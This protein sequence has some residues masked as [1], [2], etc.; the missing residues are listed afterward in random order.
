MFLYLKSKV[1]FYND[2]SICA[3][4]IYFCFVFIGLI[5]RCKNIFSRINNVCL[6]LCQMVFYE[7]YF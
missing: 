7:N 6:G 1:F 3:L 4:T 5:N 2:F